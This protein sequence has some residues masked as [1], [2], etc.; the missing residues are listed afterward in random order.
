MSHQ[1]VGLIPARGGSK[2]IPRKNIIQCGGK[3]LIAHTIEAALSSKYLNQVIVST[4]DEEIANISRSYGAD[5]PFL[6]PDECSDDDA[7]MI[8]VLRHTLKWLMNSQKQPDALVLL[9]PTSP[10]RNTKHIDEAVE[11]FLSNQA[12]S[13]VSVIEIPHQFSP[14]SALSLEA[15]FLVPLSPE[16]SATTRRQD[17]KIF[18]ARNGPAILVCRPDV[19]ESNELYGKRCMPYFMSAR[20]SIDIDEPFDLEIADYILRKK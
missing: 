19:I 2:Q 8:A 11:I 3:P 6:R 20:E 5:V 1:V 10:L 14:S 7:P 16:L 12:T 13:V 4:D 15:G 17:K 18:Y 9:Q